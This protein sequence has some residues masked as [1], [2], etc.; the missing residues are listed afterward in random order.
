MN[1]LDPSCSIDFRPKLDNKAGGVVKVCLG[2]YIWGVTEPCPDRLHQW[3][4]YCAAHHRVLRLTPKMT[5]N[6]EIL[7][8]N[9]VYNFV[10]KH[11]TPIKQ[12]ADT[13]LEAWLARTN[14]TMA[15]K[16]QLR[17]AAD[18]PVSYIV[19]ASIK[20][21]TYKSYKYHRGIYSR[22]DSYKVRVG[23]YVKLMEDV[24]YDTLIDGFCPF[25]KHVP[26]H[27][28]GDFVIEWIFKPGC[29][30]VESDYKAYESLQTS[31]FMSRSEFILYKHLLSSLNDGNYAYDLLSKG[32]LGKNQIYHPYFKASCPGR[33]MSGEMTTSLGNGFNNLMILKFLCAMNGGEF[34]GVVEGDDGLGR[35]VNCTISEQDFRD[36]GMDA[37]LKIGSDLS[38]LS[39][40]GLITN[41]ESGR[42]VTD[43]LSN[44]AEFGWTIGA[45]RFMT[46]QTMR[47]LLHGK[48]LSLRY[49]YP[50]C[51]ILSHLGDYLI[52]VTPGCNP[53]FDERDKWWY[54]QIDIRKLPP[55][56]ITY[57]ER[58]I[59]DR[60]YHIS[61]ESQIEIEEYLDSCTEIQELDCPAIRA[62]DFPHDYYDYW[63]RFVVHMP[64]RKQ[65]YY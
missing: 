63:N 57:M 19:E 47:C 25:I 14:Y 30:M 33:R 37:K 44:L 23:P 53:L 17:E 24:V 12:G 3:S 40:C 48:G 43:V 45:H 20:N 11:Y 28:R 6:N 55:R 61:P 56:D 54:T 60:L 59:V 18:N 39:F 2:S 8:E 36:V 49:A 4:C 21:E 27:L 29:L 32:H 31:E 64:T 41:S 65:F 35:L 7:F 52:R 51:P 58:D 9:F 13:S 1:E 22:K 42:L 16:E 38:E 5:R 46:D 10:H 15:R 62:L 50:S 26:V 34:V